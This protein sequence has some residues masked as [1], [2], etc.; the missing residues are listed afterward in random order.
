MPLG[1]AISVGYDIRMRLRTDRF[2]AGMSWVCLGLAG[3]AAFLAYRS[4]VIAQAS[5]SAVPTPDWKVAALSL[6]AAGIASYSFNAAYG[7]ITRQRP[8]HA[9]IAIVWLFV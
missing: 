2:L 9:S 5:Q 3:L 4:Q 8:T 7:S 1:I 6:V